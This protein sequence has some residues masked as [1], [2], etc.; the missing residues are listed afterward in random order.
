MRVS[1]GT[2]VRGVNRSMASRHRVLADPRSCRCPADQ[3]SIG[4]SARNSMIALLL[5]VADGPQLTLNQKYRNFRCVSTRYGQFPSVPPE[6]INTTE[7]ITPRPSNMAPQFSPQ[8]MHNAATG[9][10]NACPRAY[11]AELGRG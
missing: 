4:P 11:S 9:R 8:V 5:Q 1:A 2:I 7:M 6:R 3:S 10:R